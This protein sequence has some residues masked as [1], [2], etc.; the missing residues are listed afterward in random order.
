[1]ETWKS[2]SCTPKSEGKN[3]F[4]LSQQP[5]NHT[6]TL[7][8][9][10]SCSLNKSLCSIISI[11]GLQQSWGKH[12]KLKTEPENRNHVSSKK[13]STTF[14]SYPYIVWERKIETSSQFRSF[15][16]VASAGYCN[17]KVKI[18]LFN[19]NKISCSCV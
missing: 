18:T 12:F 1:M 9:E 11:C 16:C 7:P 14:K 19:N 10:N 2:G 4:Y 3:F 5:S 13:K 8:Y 17:H 15:C 6:P